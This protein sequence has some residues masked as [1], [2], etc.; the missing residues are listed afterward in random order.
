[1]T[2]YNLPDKGS[3]QWYSSPLYPAVDDLDRRVGLSEKHD[4]KDST[5][6]AALQAAVIAAQASATAANA[7]AATAQAAAVAA[8]TTANA[9]NAVK[10]YWYAYL[11][12][13]VTLANDT[14]TLL[15]GWTVDSTF[16]GFFFS[17]GVL[18]LPNVAGRYRVNATLFYEASSNTGGRLCQVFSGSVSNTLLITGG[19]S[20]NVGTN[21]RGQSAIARKTI[22]FG[23]GAQ[24]RVVAYQ[25][26]GGTLA[27]NGVSTKDTSYWQVEYVGAV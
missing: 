14:S 15:T 19:T 7:A 11:G 4:A 25:A 9:A 17:A 22:A 5:D 1:M 27:V 6:I 12:A 23:A 26:A 10:P 8:Q 18:T 13:N 2:T 3:L 16:G 20:G 24:F 21:N